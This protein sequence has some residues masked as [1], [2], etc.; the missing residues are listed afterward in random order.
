M[1]KK[2][3]LGVVTAAVL[4][5]GC[6]TSSKDIAPI[7]VSPLQYQH[8]DCSQIS[9]ELHR[10]HVRV[11]QL[12]GRLDEASG[13]DKTLTGVGAIL[14]WPALFA[15]G[16]T[17]QQEQ[18]YAR[19]KGEYEALQQVAVMR[20]CAGITPPVARPEKPASNV[21]KPPVPVAPAPA[22]A[23]DPAGQ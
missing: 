1:K 5:A 9:A 6:S 21:N 13:N 17:K 3:L 15:L 8:L 7:Y 19:L 2:L 11:N 20:K 16:G 12:A 23:P 22:A 18:D 4:T 10:I 14:F